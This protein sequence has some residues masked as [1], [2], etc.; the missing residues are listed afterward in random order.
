[1]LRPETRF[2]AWHRR[3][4]KIAR[5]FL[6]VL[7]FFCLAGTGQAQAGVAATN[8]LTHPVLDKLTIAWIRSAQAALPP[9]YSGQ[10]LTWSEI[11]NLLRLEAN[12]G[13]V[14]AQGLWGFVLATKG[15][16]ADESTEGMELLRRSA[17]RGYVPAMVE[18]GFLLKAGEFVARDYKE[19]AHWFSLAAEKEDSDAE[20]QL[21]VCYHYGLGTNRDFAVAAQWY[22]RAALQTNYVA[23][24][25]FGYVLMKGLGVDESPDAARYWFLR[26]AKE[27]GNR[28]AMYNLC[29]LSW[30]NSSSPESITEGFHWAQ[31][32]A[33]LGDPL[34][35]EAVWQCYANGY[36]LTVDRQKSWDWRAT[37]AALG[38]TESQYAMG[39][40]YRMGDGVPVD[41]DKAVA[42]YRK[43]AAKNHP[44]AL[45]DLAVHYGMDTNNPASLAE[46]R[47]FMRRAADAG[48]LDAQ[49][50]MAL[51][52]FR[53]DQGPR[54]CE[55]GERRLGD[56][57]TNG[58]PEAEF[59][60]YQLQYFGVALFRGCGPCP[61]DETEGLRWLRQA[62]DHGQPQA[63]STL[64]NAL[65]RGYKM[66][67]D[68]LAAE[69]LL[70]SSAERGFVDA[71]NDL[72]YAL[73]SGDIPMTNAI[74]AAFWLRLAASQ[75][76][77]PGTS[78][79]IKVNL[80]HAV[81]SLSVDEFLELDRREQA[82]RPAPPP[83]I[84]HL[85]KN[86]EECAAYQQEDGEY[87]R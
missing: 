6:A 38:A 18:L 82:F 80:A 31:K 46:A 17:G 43:A 47:E 72:G 2:C 64:A 62:A 71:Q 27:G 22:R 21:G 39:A 54:K 29:S 37:A 34:G 35:C 3:T 9:P 58:F 12:G 30:H 23:M 42:W 26:A 83:D 67:K 76:A 13:A 5:G 81:I 50:Q 19:S 44:I 25:C 1:M 66:P 41:W 20:L 65:L 11:T 24:K 75:T 8:S 87:G 32:S 68:P 56:A 69:K 73:L 36:G 7:G 51:H 85:A 14:A 70:R 4:L 16:S 15:R 63:Q 59:L 53:G 78:A 48:C 40:A 10:N 33:N 74:D 84:K 45:Y 61:K 77:N 60:M 28:R 86:W 79:R 57:A 52:C 55:E 49:F